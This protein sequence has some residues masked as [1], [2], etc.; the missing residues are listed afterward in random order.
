MLGNHAA[1]T[2]RLDARQGSGGAA[3]L[4]LAAGAVVAA[5]AAVRVVAED[6]SL[7]QQHLVVMLTLGM[8]VGTMLVCALLVLVGLVRARTPRAAKSVALGAAGACAIIGLGLAF[9]ANL[10]QPAFIGL[11]LVV[12]GLVV[13]AFAALRPAPAPQAAY[14]G[15]YGY[16]AGGGQMAYRGYRPYYEPPRPAPLFSEAP[17]EVESLPPLFGDDPLYA[18]PKGKHVRIFVHPKAS[19]TNELC[20][21]AYALNQRETWVALCDGTGGSN[22]PRPWAALLAQRLVTGTFP[23]EVTPETVTNWLAEP[24]AAWVKWVRETWLP[25]INKRNQRIGVP[26]VP[27]ETADE[28]VRGGASSTFLAVHVSGSGPR[29]VPFW[30]A[31]A[32]GDT[33]LLVFARIEGAWNLERA[34]PLEHAADFDDR[35][36]S[37]TSRTIDLS[38]LVPYIKHI[39]GDCDRETRLVLATD[40]L[41]KWIL[42]GVEQNG[43]RWR[44]LIDIKDQKAFDA[45]VLEERA[46]NRLGDD[47]TSL[48]VIPLKP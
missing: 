44:E 28:V 42:E 29:N 30:Q 13:V 31:W 35:P 38:T 20:E 22:F 9:I 16:L 18:Q 39:E 47:D 34:F 2:G 19:G 24:R 27:A 10:P 41:A 12:V 3:S 48:I 8:L 23:Q 46:A 21:D 1:P 4:L 7:A 25:S 26:L 5:I 33:C 43:E 17:K 15:D 36:P 40:A 14:A 6:A 32:I 11:G 37:L 45:L